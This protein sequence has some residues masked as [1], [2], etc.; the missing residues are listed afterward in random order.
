MQNWRE[1]TCIWGKLKYIKLYPFELV[2]WPIQSSD[3]NPTA[4]LENFYVH[5]IFSLFDLIDTYF[6]TFA[7]GNTTKDDSKK[8]WTECAWRSL[9]RFYCVFLFILNFFKLLFLIILCWSI[10]ENFYFRK[11]SKS[12]DW[13]FEISLS[14]LLAVSVLSVL[15]TI[16]FIVQMNFVCYIDSNISNM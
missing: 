1:T 14:Q 16:F 2:Y 10:T 15:K 5:N 7:A 6:D 11:S 12:C 4:R 8:C 9:L 13:M 3:L